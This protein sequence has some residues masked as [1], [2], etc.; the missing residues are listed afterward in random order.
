[1]LLIHPIDLKSKAGAEKRA[2]EKRE[3][4]ED[5]EGAV[6]Q[7]PRDK[8]KAALPESQSPAVEPHT[9]CYSVYNAAPSGAD[10]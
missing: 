10:R 1:M 2:S 8:A 5:A 9:R 6:L 3:T 4:L 7:D